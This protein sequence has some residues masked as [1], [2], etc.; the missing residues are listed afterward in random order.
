[1]KTSYKPPSKRKY[2]HKERKLET[3]DAAFLKKKIEL[4]NQKK[5]KK[6]RKRKENLGN[7][8]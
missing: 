4:L 7:I 8:N 1:M 3:K 6:M 5:L 2:F